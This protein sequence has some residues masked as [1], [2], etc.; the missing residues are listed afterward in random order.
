[1][2]VQRERAVRRLSGKSGAWGVQFQRLHFG[3]D[4]GACAGYPG[5]GDRGLSV[6][7]EHLTSVEELAPPFY[8]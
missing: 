7:A 5:R 3:T 8:E 1:M 4:F 6:G 2:A